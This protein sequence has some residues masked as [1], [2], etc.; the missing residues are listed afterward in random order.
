MLTRLL[1]IL[2]A[3]AAA[4]LMA[5]APAF[6]SLGGEVADGRSVAT[7]L[8]SGTTSCAT[9]SD[10]RFEHLGEFIMDRM[11]GSQAAH[12]AIN[13]RMSQALGSANTDRMHELMGRRF[14]G[15][16]TASVALM[17]PGMMR[18]TAWGWMRGD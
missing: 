12:V 3:A 6:G 11:A 18:G 16:A 5:A 7:R 17:G 2:T 13:Q 9:L 14:A 15:C 1:C 10:T 8:Q 4:V